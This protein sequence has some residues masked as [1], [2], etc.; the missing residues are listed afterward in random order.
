MRKVVEPTP[1]VE[2][3]RPERPVAPVAADFV[4][5]LMGFRLP[6]LILVIQIYF[7]QG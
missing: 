7:P 6:Y 5:Y 4:V 3:V 1:K 2:I